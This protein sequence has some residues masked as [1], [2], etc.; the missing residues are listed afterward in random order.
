MSCRNAS[1][2]KSETN[3][4]LG[5][6]TES[7]TTYTYTTAWA[8]NAIGCGF[9]ALEEWSF[10]ELARGRPIDELI[11]QVVTGNE[12][13]AIL[14]IASMLALHTETVSEVTFPLFTSQRLLAAGL[15]RQSM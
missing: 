7:V 11:Q 12:C 8:P 5:G 13:I 2:K 4:K 9:M 14:G 1:D 3:N 6:G 15:S 10:A